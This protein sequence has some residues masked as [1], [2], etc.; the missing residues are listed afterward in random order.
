M[1]KFFNFLNRIPNFLKDV[2]FEIKKINWLN[3]RE[4]L[5]YTLIVII[6]SLAVA[7]FLGSLDFLFAILLKKFVL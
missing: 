3:R 2:F 1:T 5:K 7:V 4:L 6:S